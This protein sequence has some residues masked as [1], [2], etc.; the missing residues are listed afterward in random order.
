MNRGRALLLLGAVTVGSCGDGSG[1][2]HARLLDEQGQ[3]QL[4]LDI[5]IAE[6]E[7]ERREGLRLHG[8]LSEDQALLLRFP[9]EGEACITNRGVPFPIDLVYLGADRRVTATE[10]AIPANASGPYCHPAQLVL[11]LRGGTLRDS[12]Y[13]TLELY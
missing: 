9:K 6:S 5:R 1:A 13:A 11:E 2:Q 7:L 4:E 12:Q 3:V 8:P 10:R